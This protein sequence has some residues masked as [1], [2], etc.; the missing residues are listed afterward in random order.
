MVTRIKYRTDD[1]HILDAIV[2]N[3]FVTVSWRPDFVQPCPKQH[4]LFGL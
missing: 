4:E 3:L 2:E 1:P